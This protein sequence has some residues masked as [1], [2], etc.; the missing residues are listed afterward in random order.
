M[1]ATMRPGRPLITSTRVDRY[2]ASDTE[3][4]M[5][6]PA[7]RFEHEELL[8]LGLQLQPGDLVQRAERLVEQGEVGLG[9]QRAGDRDPHPHAAG[10]RAWVVL[11]EPGEP[12]QV[13]HLLRRRR[14][15]V[16]AR[17]AAQL[18]HEL[19]VARGAAPLQQRR[20]LEDVAGGRRR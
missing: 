7:N 5:N 8:Q 4:V 18:L 10:Q 12:D 9:D 11:L 14:A 1:S 20:V 15:P 2:T 16:A 17:H 13:E 19:D 3:W 6:S